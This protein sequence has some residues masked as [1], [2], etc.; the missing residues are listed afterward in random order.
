M[1]KMTKVQQAER[2]KAITKLREMFPAGSTAKTIL[3]HVS[4]SGMMR[5]ISVISPD[6][7]DVTWLV[8][9]AMGWKM[10][11]RT[12]GI[13]VSG[14]GMDMGFHLINSL[15]GIVHGWDNRGGY[16]ISHRWL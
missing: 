7:E 2:D 6:C 14:C 5:H 4:R 15:S 11:P 16:A 13:K 8:A 1:P 12:G 9:R 10:D 3:R